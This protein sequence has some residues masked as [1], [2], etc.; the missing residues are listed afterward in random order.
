MSGHGQA[1]I[2][3]P[4]LGCPGDV[5]NETVDQL[6]EHYFCNI[7]SISGYAG[8]PANSNWSVDL[9]KMAIADFVKTE[10]FENPIVIG[11][12]FGGFLALSLAAAY[13]EMFS[14]VV[15]IDAYPFALGAIQPQ[16]TPELAKQQATKLKAY[17]LKLTNEEFAKQESATLKIAV[18]DEKNFQKILN[19]KLASNRTAIAL[20]MYESLSSDLRQ[21]M[22]N[23]TAPTLVLGSWIGLQPYGYTK[24]KISQAFHDQYKNITQCTIKV[25]DK[26]KHFIMF[27][28]INWMINNIN[29]FMN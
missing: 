4:G 27:D 21:E 2:F 29:E 28:D 9:V 8:I 12:S 13:P 3:I 10:E 22:S 19:W 25:S 16:I 17:T 24:Q 15:I 18:T 20:S 1:I 14:K 11:H 23:I 5:W 26:A 7:I 6:S